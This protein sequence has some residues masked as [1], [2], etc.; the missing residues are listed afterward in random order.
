[1]CERCLQLPARQRYPFEAWIFSTGLQDGQQHS[2]RLGTPRSHTQ[3]H[4]KLTPQWSLSWGEEQ[5]PYL[6]FEDLAVL[7]KKVTWCAS[8]WISMCVTGRLAEGRVGLTVHV[9]GKNPAPSQDDTNKT[10]QWRLL[11]SQQNVTIRGI[12]ISIGFQQ[13]FFLYVGILAESGLNNSTSE[14]Y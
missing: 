1:M 11:R 10:L 5:C 12:S 13:F 3:I 8:V 2:S 14:N 9:R 4:P 7:C 6:I